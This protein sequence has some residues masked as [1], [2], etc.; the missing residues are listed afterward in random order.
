MQ[1]FFCGEALI[2]QYMIGMLT[3]IGGGRS[4]PPSDNHLW[5]SGSGE[6]EDRLVS[7]GW[8]HVRKVL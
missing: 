5:V 6:P 8:W 7:G 3:P 2:C 1:R 4:I